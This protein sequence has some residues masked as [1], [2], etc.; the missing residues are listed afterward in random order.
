MKLLSGLASFLVGDNAE[1]YVRVAEVEY[2]RE[3][4]RFVK[5]TGRRPT[6]EE[7]KYLILG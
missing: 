2:S 4:R 5:A 7:A 6:N 3:F 1:P